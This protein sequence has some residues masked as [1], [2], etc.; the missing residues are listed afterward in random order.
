[1]IK[2]IFFDIDGTLLSFKTHKVPQ[3]TIKAIK[4]VRQKGVKIIVATG[5]LFSQISNLDELEFDGFITVN[6]SYCVDTKGKVIGKRTIPKKELE[7]LIEYEKGVESFAFAFMVHEGIFV[8][9]VD[10]TVKKIY[11]MLE[12]PTPKA[13]DLSSMIDEEVYQLNLFVDKDRNDK[14][15]QD[16]L[17]SCE[18]SRWHPI[19]SDVNIKGINKS[20]GVDDFLKYYGL[21]KEE[22]MAFGDGGNDLEMLKHVGI[23]VAMGNANDEVKA[24]AD[25]ITTSVDDDGV[26]NAMLHYG[27]ID[28]L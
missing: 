14:I 22:T 27:L 25:Y 20:I 7:S 15:M 6:G 13:A 18:S 24:I 23:G 17:I 16:A 2:A 12:I 4:A 9:K 21:K 8:N 11:G 1:M 3:S 26:A 19:F 10:D 28:S 5:R